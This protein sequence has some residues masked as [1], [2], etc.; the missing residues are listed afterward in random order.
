MDGTKLFLGFH[1]L[2]P[3]REKLTAETAGG[4]VAAPGGAVFP[5]IKDDTQVKFVPGILWEKLFQ[6][7]LGLL[8]GFAIR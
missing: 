3:F 1:R 8:H 4:A 7:S 6:I 5:A 2:Y